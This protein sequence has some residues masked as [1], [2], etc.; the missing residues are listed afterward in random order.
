MYEIRNIF[1]V[2]TRYYDL[3]KVAIQLSTN[4]DFSG[5]RKSLSELDEMLNRDISEL[6][7]SKS[8]V[9]QQQDLISSGME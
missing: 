9:I 5:A 2:N 6:E 4:N 1:F 7:G 3:S 8:L